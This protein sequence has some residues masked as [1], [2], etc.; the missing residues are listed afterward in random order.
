VDYSCV[1]R[2]NLMKSW[3]TD[4]TQTSPSLPRWGLVSLLNTN[5]ERQTRE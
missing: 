3:V 5:L 4:K 2:K 1:F